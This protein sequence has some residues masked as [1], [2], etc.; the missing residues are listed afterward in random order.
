VLY[1]PFFDHVLRRIDAERAHVLAARGLRLATARPGA[2]AA[3]RGRLAPPDPRLRVEALGLTFP[4]PLG[5]AAGLDKDATWFEGLGALG[6]GF[7]E[8]GTVTARPQAGNPRPRVHRLPADRGLLNSMGFP[9]A[10]AAAT[11]ARLQRERR[12]TIVA[13]NV[14][15]SRDTALEEAGADYRAAVAKVAPV[16]DLL[17]LNV[18]SPNTPGLRDMQATERLGALVDDVRA[19]LAAR[20]VARPVLVKLSPDLDE[21]AIDAVADL[22]LEHGLDGLV[23]VNTTT[24]RAGLASPPALLE[25]PGGVSGAPLKPRALAVLRR[26]RAKVGNELVLVSAGGVESAADAWERIAAGA[27]LVQAYTGFVYGG[28]LWPRRV[29]RE[30]ARRVAAVGLPSIQALVGSETPAGVS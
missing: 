2:A 15:K 5:V 18:S 7:V 6:F 14:G 22:A 17:V 9:N 29:N 20:G 28:P 13:V 10:G 3:L 11:A 16:A 25:R 12:G 19:E 4:S 30:L 27:T 8:V 24:A 21:E 23:A 1:A 26:L